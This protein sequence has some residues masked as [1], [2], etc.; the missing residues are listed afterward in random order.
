MLLLLILKGTAR[1]AGLLL[2]PVEDFGR[3]FF[4]PSAKKR[5]FYAVFAYFRPILCSVITS[6]TFSNNVNKLRKNPKKK[7]IMLFWPFL[8]F[9]GVQ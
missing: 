9:F 1:Y 6:V 4:C 5:A 3:G 2:A 7:L 8:A